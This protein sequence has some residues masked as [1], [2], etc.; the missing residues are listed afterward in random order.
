MRYINAGKQGVSG[1]PI[2]RIPLLVLLAMVMT[3]GRAAAQ[4]LRPTLEEAGSEWVTVDRV[5]LG[6]VDLD[7]SRFVALAPDVYQV[8]TRWRFASAQTSREGYRYQ[9]SVAVRAIDCG[10]RQAALISFADH[11]GRDVKHTE[12]QPVYAA[13]WD[14]VN[15]ESIIDRIATRVCDQGS[16]N[17]TRV[18]TLGG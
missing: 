2:V 3:A 4:D 7:V 6:A 1:S 17:A 11:D 16:R 13:R 8:R 14:A 12:A 10:K 9:T 15:P 18:T 5:E